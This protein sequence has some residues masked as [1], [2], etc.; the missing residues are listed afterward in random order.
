MAE[1]NFLK[2]ITSSKDVKRKKRKENNPYLKEKGNCDNMLIE[3]LNLEVN[4]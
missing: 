2:G 3:F 1:I 4:T